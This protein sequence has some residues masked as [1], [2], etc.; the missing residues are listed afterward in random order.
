MFIFTVDIDQ[1][2]IKIKK[3]PLLTTTCFI[4]TLCHRT[5]PQP[6]TSC[7]TTTTTYAESTLYI[8]LATTPGVIHKG[9]STLGQNRMKAIFLFLNHVAIPFLLSLL[10]LW[11][12][13]L[14]SNRCFSTADEGVANVFRLV[15]LITCYCVGNTLLSNRS[16]VYFCTCC[17][18]LQPNL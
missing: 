14:F 8:Y 4:Y 10:Y 9:S 12:Q 5:I 7:A 13:F 18:I 3:T 17:L 15:N 11:A 2:V 16:I 6:Q 1:C